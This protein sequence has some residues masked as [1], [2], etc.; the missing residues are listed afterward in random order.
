MVITSA[1]YVAVSL[2]GAAAGGAY[3]TMWGWAV[4][5]LTGALLWWWELNAALRESGTVREVVL[6]AVE[7]EGGPPLLT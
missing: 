2:V 4:A 7:F 6:T 3:G 1:L 5:S